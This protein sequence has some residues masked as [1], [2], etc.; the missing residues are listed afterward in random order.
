MHFHYMTLRNP[1]V[2]RPAGCDEHVSNG[3]TENYVLR[4]TAGGII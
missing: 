3:V 1:G 2:S 4:S